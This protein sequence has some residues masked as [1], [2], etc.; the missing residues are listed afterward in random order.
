[1]IFFI[2]STELQDSCF[3][4]YQTHRVSPNFRSLWK[5]S[6]LEFFICFFLPF[7]SHSRNFTFYVSSVIFWLFKLFM[8][9]LC[10]EK[11]PWSESR[12]FLWNSSCCS[13]GL[14]GPA[15]RH[16][17]WTKKVPFSFIAVYS[18][19]GYE[20]FFLLLFSNF[21]IHDFS[22]EMSTKSQKKIRAKYLFF[23]HQQNHE[24][25]PNSHSL[26]F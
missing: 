3:I 11:Y 13:P 1:M 19:R 15:S 7:L 22:L 26:D 14:G 16:C 21:I 4:F 2:I 18:R 17:Q 25:N 12:R 23:C 20:C 24:K 10:T 5:N 8:E 6:F 9:R